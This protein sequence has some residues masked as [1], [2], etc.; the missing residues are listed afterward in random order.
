MRRI[1]DVPST[2]NFWEEMLLTEL[3]LARYKK[4]LGLEVGSLF[5]SPNCRHRHEVRPLVSPSNP[6][7]LFSYSMVDLV[8]RIIGF[9]PPFKSP[10][11]FCELEDF[12][13]ED[14]VRFAYS[15][16][17]P[18]NTWDVW[19]GLREYYTLVSIVWVSLFFYIIK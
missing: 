2:W 14:C 4:K 11:F 1:R 17:T 19:L 7:F 3:D 15:A 9:T 5:S 13:K 10:I 18:T 12:S 6:L 8:L 16:T